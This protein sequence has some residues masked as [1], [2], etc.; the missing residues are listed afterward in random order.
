MVA[1][2]HSFA[3]LFWAG[4]KHIYTL[5]HACIYRCEP[6]STIICMKLN[7]RLCE[8]VLCGFRILGLECWEF[9]QVHE[10]EVVWRIR[11]GVFYIYIHIIRVC[12]CVFGSR[13]TSLLYMYEACQCELWGPETCVHAMHLP[14]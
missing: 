13:S 6:Y 14:V 2:V 5:W 3:S 4:H 9:T 10:R 12:M 7:H 1:H 8:I 11:H